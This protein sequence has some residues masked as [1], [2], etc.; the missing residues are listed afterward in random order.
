MKRLIRKASNYKPTGQLEK[1]IG[2]L[3]T[4]RSGLKLDKEHFKE[5]VEHYK[6]N[7]GHL[8]G[9]QGKKDYDKSKYYE[10]LHNSIDHVLKKSGL[11]K[12]K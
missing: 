9:V 6:E 7:G 11:K 8:E 5:I 2:Y 12:K 4:R 10:M 1:L 3:V